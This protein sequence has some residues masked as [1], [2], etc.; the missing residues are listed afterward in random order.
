MCLCVTT[1][2]THTRQPTHT[3]PTIGQAAAAFRGRWR[4]LFS[5]AQQ[6]AL[7]LLLHTII[8]LSP[9][10]AP[11]H[12]SAPYTLHTLRRDRPQ[13]MGGDDGFFSRTL[14]GAL[15]GAT[16]GT[17]A[18]TMT[19]F[20]NSGTFV[21][22]CSFAL[23]SIDPCPPLLP[24]IPPSHSET[25]H[26]LSLYSSSNPLSPSLPPFSWDQ[27]EPRA[28][29][30]P[31]PSHHLCQRRVPCWGRRYVQGRGGVDGDL[32]GQGGGGDQ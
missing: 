16:I 30:S 28:S 4:H 3:P 20:W 32:D 26:R 25:T 22:L 24:S 12:F 10:S 1:T 9:P 15:T 7:L 2:L 23:C 29:G 8:L 31:G 17:A 18:G 13:S 5:S 14:E 21:L 11:S 19:S 27:A 6:A